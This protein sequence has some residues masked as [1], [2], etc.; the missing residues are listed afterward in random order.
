ML[1]KPQNWADVLPLSQRVEAALRSAI[2]VPL[3]FRLLLVEMA[4]RIEQTE[5]QCAQLRANPPATAQS[6]VAPTWLVPK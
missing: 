3:P 6:E 2:L 5:N 4:Q 1:D